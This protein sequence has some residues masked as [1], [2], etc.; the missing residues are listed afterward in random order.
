MPRKPNAS[1]RFLTPDEEDEVLD[2]LARLAGNISA[3]TKALGPNVPQ[4][5]ELDHNYDKIFESAMN[6]L[7]INRAMRDKH[8]RRKGAHAATMKK[9]AAAGPRNERIIAA[10][11]EYKRQGMKKTDRVVQLAEDFKMSERHMFNLLKSAS[12]HH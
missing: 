3:L 10:E 1:V 7:V 8:D 4:L 6:I 12:D 2:G 9:R 11:R 5:A